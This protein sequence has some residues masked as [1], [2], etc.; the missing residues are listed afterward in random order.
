VDLECGGEIKGG[1]YLELKLRVVLRWCG[2]SFRATYPI[3]YKGVSLGYSN[4]V[5]V[6]SDRRSIV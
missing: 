2:A 5:F 6:G 3:I 4:S 1:E